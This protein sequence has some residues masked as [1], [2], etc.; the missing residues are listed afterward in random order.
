MFTIPRFVW[1]CQVDNGKYIV[2]TYTASAGTSGET[3]CITSTLFNYKIY[4]DLKGEKPLFKASWYI[5]YPW[6]HTPERTEEVV[7]EF[8]C[9]EDG[10]NAANEWLDA[11]YNKFESNSK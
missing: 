1:F 3:G 6:G 5:R 10:L 7:N 9:S 4:V 8:E 2:N 11:E